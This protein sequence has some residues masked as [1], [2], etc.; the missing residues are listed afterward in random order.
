LLSWW[1]LWECCLCC[2]DGSSKMLVLMWAL[3]LLSWW[4]LWEKTTISE[5]PGRQQSQSSHE[6]N[7]LG[8]PMKTTISELTSRQ[9]SQSS[10]EDSNLRAPIKTTISELPWRQ[11]SL[12]LWD[13]CLDGNSQMVGLMGRW[14][15]CL[16]GSSQMVVLMGALK[17]LS[18]WELWESSHQDNHLR[19]P[20]KTTPSASHQANHLRVA[21]KT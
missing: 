4:E 2:L 21:I 7:N 17:L 11:Q 14:G 5:L 9:Q 3:R 12:A 10:H 20:I 18:W 19:A 13:L 1:E 6:D 16:D 15:C 8:A